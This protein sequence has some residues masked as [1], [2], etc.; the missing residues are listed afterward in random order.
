M[1]TPTLS[2][3]K[4]IAA[5][6]LIAALAAGVTLAVRASPKPA[7]VLED[8]AHLHTTPPARTQ[9]PRRVI[10]PS[11]QGAPAAQAPPAPRAGGPEPAPA[12]PAQVH[13]PSVA[14][15]AQ[16][17]PE[18][19]PDILV[20][21]APKEGEPWAKAQFDPARAPR[22]EGMGPSSWMARQTKEQAAQIDKT[23]D[24]SLAMNLPQK[25]RDRQLVQRSLQQLAD[26]A[27]GACDPPVDTQTRRVVLGVSVQ[28]SARSARVTG[29]EIKHHGGV[30]DDVFWGCL[31]GAL[32]GASVTP[33]L[34]QGLTQALIPLEF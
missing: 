21:G 7:P 9:H 26:K 30:R 27:L 31:T 29:V 16:S 28:S 33:P 34:T 1:N 22:Q 11:V 19:G 8:G 4:M 2:A 14:P 25:Q 10:K 23:I 15:S 5:V 17:D 24:A 3:P 6:L 18:Q 20:I 32:Q 13:R 12:V